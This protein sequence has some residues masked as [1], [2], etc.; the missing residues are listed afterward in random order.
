MGLIELVVTLTNLLAS[1]DNCVT[2]VGEIDI[3][4]YP[5]IVATATLMRLS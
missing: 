4:I 1:F 2:F 3:N 5:H